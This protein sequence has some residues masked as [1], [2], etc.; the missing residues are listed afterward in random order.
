MEQYKDGTTEVSQADD[1]GEVELKADRDKTFCGLGDRCCDDIK[2]LTQTGNTL[3]RPKW[4]KGKKRTI[5]E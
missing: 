2:H 5:S 4:D 3:M 1:G